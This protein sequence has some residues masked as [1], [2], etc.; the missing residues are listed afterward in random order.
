[1]PAG[2]AGGFGAIGID[3]RKSLSVR[4]IDGYLP[5]TVFSTSVLAQC[6]VLLSFLQD[7]F[8]LESQ[9]YLKFYPPPQVLPKV[10]RLPRIVPISS[11]FP[12]FCV[13]YG[14]RLN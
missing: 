5:M 7:L 10:T 2:K 1:L 8:Q 13:F 9:K 6:G 11:V 4:V 12:R 14:E 3:A